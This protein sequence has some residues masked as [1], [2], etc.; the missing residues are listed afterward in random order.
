MRI[1][2]TDLKNAGGLVERLHT[3]EEP[4]SVST[5]F[6]A[7]ATDAACFEHAVSE[8]GKSLTSGGHSLTIETTFT[9]NL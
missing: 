1:G 4:L 2:A 7:R 5:F 8:G 6:V 3:S 9:K